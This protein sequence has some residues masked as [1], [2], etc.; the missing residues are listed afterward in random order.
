M[1]DTHDGAGAGGLRPREF[2]GKSN[3]EYRGDASGGGGR[4][5]ARGYI[6]ST[7]SLAPEARG[8]AS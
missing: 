5:W 6:L 8:R 2:E 7:P 3:R 4:R 1:T